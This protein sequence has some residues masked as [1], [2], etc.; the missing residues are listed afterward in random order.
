MNV[1]DFIL[2]LAL[3]RNT[4]FHLM[5]LYC[6]CVNENNNTGFV[7]YSIWVYY[8]SGILCHDYALYSV[9]RICKELFQIIRIFCHDLTD[10]SCPKL[11]PLNNIYKLY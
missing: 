5:V 10:M 7:C 3:S 2:V 11:T 4:L 1:D 8:Y 6:R 9:L